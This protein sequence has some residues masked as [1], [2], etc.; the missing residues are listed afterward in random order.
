[1]YDRLRD[2]LI[3]NQYRRGTGS[4]RAAQAV[5]AAQRNNPKKKPQSATEVIRNVAQ[6]RTRRSDLD[7]KIKKMAGM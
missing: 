5:A 1:M 3:E 2:L 7:D 4:T 6:A